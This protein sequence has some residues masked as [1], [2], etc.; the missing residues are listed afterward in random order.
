MGF[1]EAKAKLSAKFSNFKKNNASKR[2][3]RIKSLSLK[4]KAQRKEA[5]LRNIES[6]LKKQAFEGSRFGKLV[7]GAKKS[8]KQPA[9]SSKKSSVSFF[10]ESSG[11]VGVTAF[12]S[13]KKSSDDDFKI[14]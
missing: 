8:L 7:K 6:N 14:I 9:K 12:D 5:K 1:K 2:K 10:E 3:E 4:V 13:G 11:G